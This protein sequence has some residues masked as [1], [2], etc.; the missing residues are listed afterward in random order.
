MCVVNVFEW[1][2]VCEIF[3][4]SGYYLI[5][6]IFGF[7]IYDLELICGL[8]IREVYYENW[9][10]IWIEILVRFKI[11]NIFLLNLVVYS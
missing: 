4:R 2:K 8:G 5:F 6:E 1:Y 11:F 7:L 3:C 10:F 9:I